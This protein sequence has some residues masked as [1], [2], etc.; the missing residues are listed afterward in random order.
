MHR[1]P[2][3]E[4][5]DPDVSPANSCS[6][7]CNRLRQHTGTKCGFEEDGRIPLKHGSVLKSPM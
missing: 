1:V 2:G 7:W 6:V 3:I 4:S 5:S